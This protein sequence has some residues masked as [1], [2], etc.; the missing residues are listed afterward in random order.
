MFPHL[1][2]S[3]SGFSPQMTSSGLLQGSSSRVQEMRHLL[4]QKCYGITCPFQSAILTPST[5]HC[6][7]IH[8]CRASNLEQGSKDCETF[9]GDK[10]LRSGHIQVKPFLQQA[11]RVIQG[12][13]LIAIPGLVQPP[14]SLAEQHS[15]LFAIAGTPFYP[16]FGLQ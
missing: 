9:P 15:G 6:G 14:A 11:V 12:V 2:Y 8:A 1:L 3:S 16:S 7:R 4:S 5:R 13:P 10:K